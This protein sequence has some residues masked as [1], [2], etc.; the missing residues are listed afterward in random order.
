VISGNA[1]VYGGGGV[2]FVDAEGATNVIENSVVSSNSALEGGGVA[3]GAGGVARN[4][5]I[6]SNTATAHGGGAAI[7]GD[8]YVLNCTV[9]G[10]DAPTAGGI[11]CEDGGM[12]RNAIVCSN[13]VPEY[14]WNGVGMSVAYCRVVT[15]AGHAY[16]NITADPLLADPAAGDFRLL[17]NSPCVDAGVP[18][19]GVEKDMAGTPRPLD[20]NGDGVAR[21]DMGAWEYL[22]AAADSD[23]DGMR[24]GDEGVAGTDPTDAADCLRISGAAVWPAG[25]VI[26][27]PSVSGRL[28]SVEASTDLLYAPA[29][30]PGVFTNVPGVGGVMRCTNAGASRADFLRIRV[31]VP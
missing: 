17:S 10:N 5:L 24:D 28:Y 19:A 9:Y 2:C 22:N 20:G 14:D 31:N 3:L 27:W 30:A 13:A 25:E 1:S 11:W 16:S 18:L 15:S 12:V 8:G 26:E 21:S 6:V 7:N 29:F 4:C 23:N